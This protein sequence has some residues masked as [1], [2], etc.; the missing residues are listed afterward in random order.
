MTHFVCLFVCLFAY[1]LQF[2]LNS[3]LIITSTIKLIY[4]WY[5]G[6]GL[7]LCQSSLSSRCVNQSLTLFYLMD[8]GYDHWFFT[9]S[10]ISSPFLSSFILFILQYLN[11]PHLYWYDEAKFP[12][13][14][15][16]QRN[17]VSNHH[18]PLGSSC[19]EVVNLWCCPLLHFLMVCLVWYSPSGEFLIVSISVVT[20]TLTSL[21]YPSTLAL[22]RFPTD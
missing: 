17:Q 1:K 19:R 5:D 7:F 22:V 6:I 4:I 15:S 16:I 13:L 18:H 11:S 3:S 14:Y 8:S 12:C 2:F 10:S 20:Q 9:S 21:V